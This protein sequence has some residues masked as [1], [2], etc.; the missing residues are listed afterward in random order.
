MLKSAWN[1]A[2][3]HSNIYIDLKFSDILVKFFLGL[4]Q[5]FD[6]RFKKGIALFRYFAVAAIFSSKK[7]KLYCSSL[8][9]N[10]SIWRNQIDK[11]NQIFFS[12]VFVLSIHAYLT[13]FHKSFT[14][15][16]ILVFCCIFLVHE[17]DINQ[18]TCTLFNAIL[19]HKFETLHLSLLWCSC[20]KAFW[21]PTYKKVM[22]NWAQITTMFLSDLLGF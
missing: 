14:S 5:N 11:Q 13:L 18:K 8:L 17:Q 21:W 3:F 19:Y 2:G 15:N 1:I 7:C 20:N 16:E 12:T 6:L 10:S 22:S 4:G 9:S